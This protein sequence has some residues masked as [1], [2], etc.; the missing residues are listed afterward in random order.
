MKKTVILVLCAIFA[1]FIFSGCIEKIDISKTRGQLVLEESGVVTSDSA[2]TTE[3]PKPE[4]VY[5]SAAESL[6]ETVNTPGGQISISAQIKVPQSGDIQMLYVQGL[7][8]DINKALSAVLGPDSKDA[9]AEDESTYKKF[10]A[11][12]KRTIYKSKKYYFA[13]YTSGGMMY[14]ISEEY[15]F[16]PLNV[17][18]EKEL[19]KADFTETD[20]LDKAENFLLNLGIKNNDVELVNTHCCIDSKNDVVYVI[21]YANKI[22]GKRIAFESMEGFSGKDTQNGDGTTLAVAK[23]GVRLAGIYTHTKLEDA[24]LDFSPISFNDSWDKFKESISSGAFKL[25]DVKEVNLVLKPLDRGYQDGK[26]LLVPC[27][28]LMS[29]SGEPQYLEA[30]ILK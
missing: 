9:K 11:D 22:E 12:F 14:K 6:V 2:K 4:A 26:E 30:A 18:T 19:K 24:G 5:R 10:G 8:F 16:S 1:I 27:W 13:F 17:P 7:P 29:A 3:A 25:K 23:D 28:E 15:K 20:A 21:N